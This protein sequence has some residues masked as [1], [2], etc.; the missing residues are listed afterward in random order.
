[1]FGLKTHIDVT[2]YQIK[3]L[4]ENASMKLKLTGLLL[5]LLIP[6]GLSSPALAGHHQEE[7]TSDPI[8]AAAKSASA[9]LC[10]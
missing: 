7:D 8:A 10:G 4:A 6:L 5:T 1:M 2:L 3:I 9:A